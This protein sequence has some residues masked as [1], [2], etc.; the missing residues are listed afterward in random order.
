[1]ENLKFFIEKV[2]VQSE[3]LCCF[4]K[5]SESKLIGMMKTV[6]GVQMLWIYIRI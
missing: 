6:N 3:K 1:M 5:E 4:I 2:E